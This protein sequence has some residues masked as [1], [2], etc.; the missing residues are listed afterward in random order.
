MARGSEGSSPTWDLVLW[1]VMDRAPCQQF[2]LKW[3]VGREWW[4][5]CTILATSNFSLSLRLLENT[6][7]IFKDVMGRRH[8]FSVRPPEPELPAERA[9]AWGR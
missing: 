2:T 9:P 4:C 3:F 7:F 6:K 5:S 8:G 1:G